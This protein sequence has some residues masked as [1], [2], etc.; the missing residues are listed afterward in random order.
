MLLS[1][2]CVENYRAGYFSINFN[3]CLNS[4]MPK[5]FVSGINTS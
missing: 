1:F 3:F 4:N 2:G 5:V